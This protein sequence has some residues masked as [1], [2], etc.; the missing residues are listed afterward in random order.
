[1]K[2]QEVSRT[3]TNKAQSKMSC[4]H[5]V[6]SSFASTTLL[7]VSWKISQQALPHQHP[8][9]QLPN[10]LPLSSGDPITHHKGKKTG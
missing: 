4:K 1:M 2:K 3:Q 5:K 9:T 10:R 6:R 7:G 8:D